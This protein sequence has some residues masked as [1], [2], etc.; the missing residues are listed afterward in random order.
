MPYVMGGEALPGRKRS[1]VCNIIQGLFVSYTKAAQKSPRFNY[2]A[3]NNQ[4]PLTL[5]R[6]FPLRN[7]LRTL[8]K[9]YKRILTN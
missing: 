6:I 3:V 7:T 2:G 8:T 5:N 4:N 9:G 1:L